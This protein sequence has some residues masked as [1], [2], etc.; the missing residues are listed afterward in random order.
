M[1]RAVLIV[2]GVSGV[3]KSTIARHL[4]THLDWPFQEGDDLHPPANVAKMHRG[5]PLTDE[6]RLPW[7]HAIKA[8]IDARVAA[9]EPGLVTCSALKR[10]YR[11]LLIDHRDT[12]RILYLH[13]DKATIENHLARRTGHFMPPTLL[14]SQLQTL[15]EPSPD[16]HPITVQVTDTVEGTVQSILHALQ[17]TP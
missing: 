12:V 17:T 5:I 6:D 4:N 10:A 8:W 7:L 3:G 13:A 11:D 9:G 1:I 14:D 2:M 15:E 16:E